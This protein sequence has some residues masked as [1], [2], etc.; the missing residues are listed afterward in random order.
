M[1]WLVQGDLLLLNM[2]LF[3]E[4]HPDIAVVCDVDLIVVVNPSVLK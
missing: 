1:F 2:N 3:M 4:V